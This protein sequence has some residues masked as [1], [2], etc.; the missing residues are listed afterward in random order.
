MPTRIMILIPRRRKKKG[1]SSMKKISDICP[2]V[3]VAAGSAG[4]LTGLL[5]GKKLFALSSQIIG[6]NITADEAYFHQE[7][8]RI[9][10]EFCERYK[11]DISVE[12]TDFQ[13]IDEY[14]GAGYAQSRPEELHFIAQVAKTEGIIL[15]PTYTGKAMYGLVQEIH[16]GT[17]KKGDKLLFVHTGGI[18]GLFPVAAEISKEVFKLH[19]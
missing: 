12:N 7:V 2:S 11:A 1:I 13:I 14:V 10:E 17:F 8:A 5:I 18:F 3:I 15:D 6:I 19:Y 4:T 16:R 9:L